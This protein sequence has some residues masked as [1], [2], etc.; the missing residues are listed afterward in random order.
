MIHCE[1]SFPDDSL[2][3]TDGTVPNTLV[4]ANCEIVKPRVAAAEHIS[5]VN[6]IRELSQNSN[7]L[8][9]HTDSPDVLIWDIESQPNRQANLA[10]P[11]SRPNLAR[12]DLRELKKNRGGSV[13]LVEADEDVLLVQEEKGSKEEWSKPN[14]QI[15]SHPNRNMAA[16]ED[17]LDLACDCDRMSVVKTRWFGVNAGRRF[18]E[19]GQQ[20]CAYFVWIDP[21]LGARAVEAIEELHEMHF[22]ALRRNSRRRD[23]L[24][25]RHEAETLNLKRK[26]GFMVVAMFIVFS[27]MM[28]TGLAS[29]MPDNVVDDYESDEDA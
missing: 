22:Q 25:E 28:S 20:S 10:S 5:E 24:I 27:V 3:K 16:T 13:S 12:E 15:T 19:C 6:R 21:P 7:I 4:I 14:F 17:I 8:A 11:A 2:R 9:T 26:Q 23:S 29:V 18:R 1:K